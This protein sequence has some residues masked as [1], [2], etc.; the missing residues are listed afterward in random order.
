MV[1]FI[2]SS[3][4][5]TYFAIKRAKE[6]EI[7]FL[8]PKKDN[9]TRWD[10]KFLMIESVVVQMDELNLALS[11]FSIQEKKKVKLLDD[12]EKNIIS[13][14]YGKLGMFRNVT[15]QGQ[16][17]DRSIGS[18]IPLYYYINSCCSLCAESELSYS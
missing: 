10:S 16:D 8:V 13:T 12:E 5:F 4:K 18:L 15:I 1:N 7:Q 17:E 2:R 6:K 9:Q 14:L 3:A 11:E